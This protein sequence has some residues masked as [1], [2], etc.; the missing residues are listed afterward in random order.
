MILRKLV[1]HNRVILHFVVIINYFV[2]ILLY[3]NKP[4]FFNEPFF[5]YALTSF[6]LLSIL[7]HIKTTL[8]EWSDELSNTTTEYL[9]A[10]SVIRLCAHRRCNLNFSDCI[11]ADLF[12]FP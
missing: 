2:Q 4:C 10:K 6:L 1:A 8:G 12:N 7:E 5:K 11:C 3:K 9:V